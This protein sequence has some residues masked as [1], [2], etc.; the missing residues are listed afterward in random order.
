MSVRRAR[1]RRGLKVEIMFTRKAGKRKL[2]ISVW[3]VGVITGRL[4]SLKEEEGRREGVKETS[5]HV[6]GGQTEGGASVVLEVS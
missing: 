5:D 4:G 3:S 6:M 2:E 1:Q